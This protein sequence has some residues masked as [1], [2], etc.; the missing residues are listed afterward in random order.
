MAEEREASAGDERLN[1]GPKPAEAVKQGETAESA[2]QEAAGDAAGKTDSDGSSKQPK[3]DEPHQKVEDESDES[4]TPP[5]PPVDEKV[6]AKNAFFNP[7]FHGPVW[8]QDGSGKRRQSINRTGDADEL[9]ESHVESGTLTALDDALSG[10]AAIV[11]VYGNA[12]MGK[13]SACVVALRRGGMAPILQLPR[14]LGFDDLA[15]SI[16]HLK[17]EHENACFLLANAPVS[18]VEKLDEYGIRL[19]TEKLRE[20]GS[21]RLLITTSGTPSKT[22]R[23]LVVVKASEVPK[24]ALVAAYFK[25]FPA[26][27]ETVRRIRHVAGAQP[28]TLSFAVLHTMVAKLQADPSVSDEDLRQSLPGV[29]TTE[30]LDRWFDTERSAREV[31]ALACVATCEHAPRT[32]VDEQVDVLEA[33]LVGDD[34]APGFRRTTAAGLAAG[35]V[36]TTTRPVESPYGGVHDEVVYVLDAQLEPVQVLEY[37]WTHEGAGFRK[38][39]LEWLTTLVG[40]PTEL[41]AGAVKA[42]GVLLTIDPRYVQSTLIGPWALADGYWPSV[43]AAQALGVPTI[44]DIPSDIGLRLAAAWIDS[45]KF[46]LRFCAIIAYGDLLGAWE[47]ESEAPIRLW[48]ETFTGDRLATVAARRLG[49]LCAAG[50]DARLVRL[51]V[52][53]LLADV[54][55]GRWPGT[56]REMR[57]A[58]WVFG[59]AVH[60]LTIDDEV[61][62]ESLRSLLGEHEEEA[63]DVFVELLARTWSAPYARWATEG[64][65]RDLVRAVED[66]RMDRRVV[67]DLIRAAKDVARTFGAVA[68]LGDGLRRALALERR[69]NP[70]G[71]VARRLLDQ[72]FPTS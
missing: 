7:Q 69:D 43:A 24:F 39:L 53:N 37:L 10:G 35:L 56:R 66:E 28:V 5:T 31:A 11:A 72:F 16:E 12:G 40:Y 34:E 18:F 67:T 62:A 38:G 46:D 6:R 19:L 68:A 63:K 8:F 52:L 48:L 54:A 42:A 27:E 36:T 55:S 29:V 14:D 30:A 61:A 32:D 44:L 59:Y 9:A 33:K 17:S 25:K 57:Q 65:V 70:D 64:I 20:S 21:S 26:D 41:W 2:A 51:A 13:R 45:P 60:A 58:M 50:D 4:T 1:G 71:V 23:A 22:D 47:V 49:M 15:A 3:A